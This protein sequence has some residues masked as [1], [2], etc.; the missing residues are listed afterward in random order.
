MASGDGRPWDLAFAVV[1]WDTP[2]LQQRNYTTQ[3][4][5]RARALGTNFGPKD[6]KRLKNSTATSEELAAKKKT[7]NNLTESG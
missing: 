5:L 7:K 3:K 4:E 6:T 1:H 2:L